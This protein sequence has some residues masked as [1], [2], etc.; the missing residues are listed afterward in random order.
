MSLS[1]PSGVLS[2]SHKD[3]LGSHL[4]LEM[5]TPL[6]HLTMAS[7]SLLNHGKSIRTFQSFLIT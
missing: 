6:L 2:F 5:L 7:Q 3:N 1:L 4:H